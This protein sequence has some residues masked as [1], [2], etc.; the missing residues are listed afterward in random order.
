MCCSSNV[1]VVAVVTIVTVVS[2]VTCIIGESRVLPLLPE[3]D[4]KDSPLLYTNGPARP[5]EREDALARECLPIGWMPSA[6]QPFAS[7][8]SKVL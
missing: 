8:A 3:G 5:A 2:L 6:I 7:F 4:R 1:A